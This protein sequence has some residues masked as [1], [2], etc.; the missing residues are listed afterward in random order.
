MLEQMARRLRTQPLGQRSAGS[1][2]RNPS[3]MGVSA[4]EL[5][6]KA[7]LKGLRV[8]E[9]MVS[10]K[11]ANFFINCGCATSQDMLELI[12]FVN[13]A[14]NQ[15]FGVELKEEILYIHPS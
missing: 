10:N 14:V 12:G 11:H 7:G 3:S 1:I 4:A 2:F 15:K 8:G 9:A 13:D 6:E 5:I